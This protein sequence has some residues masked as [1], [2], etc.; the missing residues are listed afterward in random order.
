MEIDFEKDMRIDESALDVEWLNQPELAMK[1]SKHFADCH[2]RLLE[3]EEHIKL[4]RS[5]LVR[6]AN[7]DPDY[8]LGKGVK[9]TKDNVEAFYREH[10]DHIDAKKEIIEAQYELDIASAAK[11]E[12]S[13][14]RKAALENLVT[15]HGQNYFAGPSVPRDLSKEVLDTVKRQKVDARIGKRLK[16]KR[17]SRNK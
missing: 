10:E 16:E 5:Q 7:E 13:F 2:K 17:L 12:I 15:L 6:K 14:S 1:Y 9:P 3:A 11:S 8:C 4:V